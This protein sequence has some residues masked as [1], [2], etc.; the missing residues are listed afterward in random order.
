[1]VVET[2]PQAA[3]VPHVERPADFV[4]ALSRVLDRL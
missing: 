3:H 2:I 1:V 4:A